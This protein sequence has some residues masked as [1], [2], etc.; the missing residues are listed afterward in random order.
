VAPFY[1]LPHKTKGHESHEFVY[2]YTVPGGKCMRMVIFCLVLALV[3]APNIC[4][5]RN[6]W[7]SLGPVGGAISSM[8]IDPKNPEILYVGTASGRVFRSVNAGQSWQS[9]GKV[10]GIAEK[11]GIAVSVLVIDPTNS[12]TLYAVAGS[13]FKSINGGAN[14]ARISDGIGGSQITSLVIRPD[15]HLT[16]Y[17]GT[18]AAGIYTTGSG[19]MLWDSSNSGIGATDITC[20]AINPKDPNTLYAGSRGPG[21]KLYKS[22]DAGVSWNEAG[23]ANEIIGVSIDPV[24]TETVYATA[25]GGATMPRLY[26][27]TDGGGQWIDISSTAH[28]PG[29]VAIDPNR[30]SVLFAA[31]YEATDRAVKSMDAGASWA[32]IGPSAVYFK[33]FYVNPQN[34]AIVYA[35]SDRMGVYKSVDGGTS[36]RSANSGLNAMTI[37]SLAIDQQN[38]AVLYAASQAAVIKSASG[39]REWLDISMTANSAMGAAYLTIDPQKPSTVY[40]GIG[41]VYGT[42][43]AGASWK[44]L[45][46]GYSMLVMVLDPLAPFIAYAG[47]S[48]SGILGS[49]D[50]GASWSRMSTGLPDVPFPALA[51]DTHN[52]VVLYAGS[53]GKGIFKS[54]DSAAT[55]VPLDTGVADL[56]V[57]QIAIDPQNYD[58]IYAA[59]TE[60][61]IIKSLN[62]GISWSA[63]N[64]GLGGSATTIAIDPEDPKTLYAG[65][66]D[67]GVY[68]STD[69]GGS[70]I[71]WSSGIPDASITALAVDLGRRKLYAGTSSRG[72]WEALMDAPPD[73]EVKAGGAAAVLTSGTGAAVRDG[74]A[75]V[76]VEAGPTPYGTA[77]FSLRQNGI[78]VS[79]AG[80]PASPPTIAA[81]LFVEHT[82]GVHAVPARSE[83]GTVD[84][85]TGIAVVNYSSEIAD[86]IY[87]LR[88]SRGNTVAVGNGTIESGDH[89]ACFIDQ[90]KTCAAPNFNFPPD[91]GDT[92]RFGTLDVI[93]DQPLSVLALRGTVNQRDEFLITTT[94]VADLTKAPGSG[95]IYF[96]QFVD[97]AGYT[98]SLILLNTSDAIETGTLL[99]RDQDGNPL[100]VRPAGKTAGSLFTYSIEPGGV[101]Q[102]QTDGS[103]DDL[104]AGW[105]RLNPDPNT[106]APVGSGIFGF[107][108]EDVLVSESGIPTSFATMGVRVYVD[109]SGNHDTGLAIANVTDTPAT[110]TFTAYRKDGTA[111]TGTV[112]IPMALRGNCYKAAF[113]GEFVSGLPVGFTGVLDVESTAPFAAL[114]LRSLYN[115]RKDFLMTTLPVA[116]AGRAAPSPMVFPHIVDGGGYTTEFI[117]LS[118][119]LQSTNH[120]FLFDDYGLTVE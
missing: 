46:T 76:T 59:T 110:F 99:I 94:P 21:A 69:G 81:R 41:S 60:L 70:W 56:H 107:N 32:G 2:I 17:V 82:N 65:T 19:G 4:V 89:V 114:T 113:A 62:G 40:G 14:W 111:M 91:F 44:M 45:N 10:D 39:G 102:L 118:P 24:D 11:L 120:L 85:N 119:D 78:V 77:V 8:A 106:A 15:D 16:L 83:A 109:L 96:P 20:L 93:G 75:E 84:V 87:I 88:D 1:L 55:W 79:E 97:G 26:K 38:P 105:V 30:P 49:I 116:D 9:V 25:G 37:E 112:G 71:A 7:S 86:V 27:S 35:L 52:P 6:I 67:R 63:A 103:P 53:S 42:T 51:I 58:A 90:L 23:I 48:D 22:V 13:L 92:T 80:V 68:K 34:S 5:A 18:Y 73:L 101:F 33:S 28:V 115:E 12:S 100:E 74:Y 98:T 3:V 95:P 31:G 29:N 54:T 36:W 61:G 43:D 47:T 104:K 64:N 50:G 108:P 66:W 117:L 57:L 72:L